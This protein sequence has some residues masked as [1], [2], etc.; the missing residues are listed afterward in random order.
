MHRFC[1]AFVLTLSLALTLQADWPQFRGP[2]GEGHAA[3]K[4]LPT[5]WDQK[6]NVTWRKE[7]PGLGWSSPVI[8]SGRIY[9]TT[10][11]PSSTAP[12]KE[13]PADYSLRTVCLDARTGEVIWN[14]EVFTED[15]K[16]TP[17]PH[18]KNSHASPTAVIEGDKLYVHFGHLGTACLNAKDGS[19]VW[20]NQTLKYTPVHGNGGSPVVVGD[21]LIFAIDGIEKQA[22]IGLDKH[23][24]KVTWE[25]PRNAKP[26]R[27]FSFCTPLL[28]TVNGQ[29]QVVCPGSEAVLSCDPKTGKEIWR[30][31]YESGYSIVPRPVFGNGLVYF[32]TGYDNPVM[33]A[34]KPDGTGDV[35]KTHVA[36]ALKKQSMPRNA[37]PLLVGDALY[38][39]SDDGVLT[40]I[41]AKAGKERWEEPL[42]LKYSASPIDAGG[43]IYL[44]SEDGTGTV[45]KAGSEFEQVSKNKLGEKALASYAVDGDALFI[46]TEKALYRMEKK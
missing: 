2:T 27:P 20:A 6:K 34:V 29:Q 25:T 12:T 28:I 42:N 10:A 24:G 37:S 38:V 13:M 11:V 39:V 23:T 45:F 30:V 19:K 18:S 17:K 40:C 5:E 46:R 9:L 41:D 3:S 22:L 15:G 36:W 1:L 21:K 33:Y 7:V 26:A 43:L 8:A 35:T 14:V 4:N 44:L 31:K 32:S 16:S